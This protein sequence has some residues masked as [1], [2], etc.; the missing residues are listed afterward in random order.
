[1][2]TSTGS[3][4]YT[5]RVATASDLPALKFV[6]PLLRADPDRATIVHAAVEAGGCFVAQD[7]DEVLGY[8]L[9]GD[10][11]GHRFINLLVVAVGSRRQG[12]GQALLDEACRKCDRPKLFI[13]CNRSNVAAQ[14]LFEK[15]G[16]RRSGQIYNLDQGDAEFVYYKEVAV[17]SAPRFENFKP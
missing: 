8:L 1:V 9:N 17:R 16:F 13:S 4:L 15:C 6:D 10:L 14:G 12:V 3:P 11:L 5:I 7:G 2:G